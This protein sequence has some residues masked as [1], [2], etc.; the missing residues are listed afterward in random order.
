MFVPLSK[1]PDHVTYDVT[2]VSPADLVLQPESH[3][4]LFEYGTGK[5]S[6]AGYFDSLLNHVY[7]YD[8]E[9]LFASTVVDGQPQFRTVALTGET[10]EPVVNRLVALRS[11]SVFVN[12]EDPTPVY[13]ED[14]ALVVSMK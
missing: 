4:F 8:G 6:D 10:P 9:S 13:L 2:N 7:V 5:T 3:Y 1:T 12:A 14:G 11:Y